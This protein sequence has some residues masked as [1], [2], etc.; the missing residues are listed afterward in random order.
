MYN[1]HILLIH[2]YSKITTSQSMFF[3]LL[4]WFKREKDLEM[5]SLKYSAVNFSNSGVSFSV[6]FY[7]YLFSYS[8]GFSRN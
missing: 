2:Y 5:F 1:D 7:E 4:S 8:I 3:T 6:I